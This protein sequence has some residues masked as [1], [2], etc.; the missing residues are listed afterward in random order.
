MGN[1]TVNY[2]KEYLELDRLEIKSS[3]TGLLPY[4]IARRYHALPISRDG[5]K[6]TV[7]MADPSDLEAKNVILDS[8]GSSTFFVKAD[9][10]VIDDSLD[11]I[12]EKQSTHAQLILVWTPMGRNQNEIE[13]YAADLAS[14]LSF[15]VCQ[16]RCHG[17][18]K[19][20][21]RELADELEILNPHLM[22]FGVPQQPAPVRPPPILSEP[23]L[24]ECLPVSLLFVHKPRLP[25]KK[26][27][28]VINHVGTDDNAIDWAVLLARR[29][30]AAITI[31]PILAPIPLMYSGFNRLRHNLPTLLTTNCPLGRKMRQ[32]V[33]RLNEWEIDGTLRLRGEDPEWQIRAELLEGDYDLIIIACERH[34]RLVDYVCGGFMKSILDWAEQP[35][36][37]PKTSPV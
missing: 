12:W 26:L 1:I 25:L 8:L 9:L 21:Y 36:L 34:N 17:E 3:I 32:I 22:I 7:V 28:L 5:K 11:L 23:K 13:S 31:L 30:G 2:E 20:I 6:I 24:V 27:L 4:D 35:V 18:G 29:S 37:I 33:R 15:R 14:L 10:Q 16:S 19:T